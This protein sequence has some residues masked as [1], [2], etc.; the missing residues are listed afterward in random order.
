MSSAD[1]LAGVP[2][3][4]KEPHMWAPGGAELPLTYVYIDICLFH[5]CG[6]LLVSVGYLRVA[7]G[8]PMVFDGLPMH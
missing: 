5:H 2:L 3:G 8:C 7:Y 4:G 1:L 6:C